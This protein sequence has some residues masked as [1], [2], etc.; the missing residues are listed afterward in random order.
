MSDDFRASL[1][2]QYEVEQWYY[3]EA[4]LLDEYAV[5]QQPPSPARGRLGWL[6]GCA[7]GRR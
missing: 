5:Q 4:R 7:L 2:L 1:E 3:R 6:G